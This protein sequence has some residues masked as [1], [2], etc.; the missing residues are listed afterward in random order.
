VRQAGLGDSL[1]PASFSQEGLLKQLSTRPVG[2]WVIQEF[3]AFQAL[4]GRDYQ[5][6][7]IEQTLTE[8]HDVPDVFVRQL[9][10]ADD[11]FTLKHRA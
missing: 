6:A 11:S 4:L 8:L 10:K 3:A 9:R 1:L 7:A 5:P 2:L